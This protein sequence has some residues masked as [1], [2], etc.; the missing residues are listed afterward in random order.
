I[1]YAID[2]NRYI[3]EM[4]QNTNLR[5]NS[6]L[7]PGI[8]GYQPAK[9]LR[10]RYDPGLAK[11]YLKLAAEAEKGKL[12]AIVYSTR[13]NQAINLLEAELIKEMLEAIGLEVKI[14]VLSF[15][16]FLTKGRAGELM[17]FTDVWLFDYPSGEDILQL[18]VSSNFPG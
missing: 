16:D 6:L 13:G 17:F 2:Y 14:Q 1:A 8:A 10:F 7:V 9:D 11:E 5:A 18:L 4:S 15:S 12:P 3:K